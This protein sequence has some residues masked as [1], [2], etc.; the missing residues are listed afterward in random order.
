V[1]VAGTA[2][3]SP[4]L[5]P[6]RNDKDLFNDTEIFNDKDLF[7]DTEIFNDKDFSNDKEF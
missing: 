4:G 3:S 1:V 2:G 6:V 5:R 7:N